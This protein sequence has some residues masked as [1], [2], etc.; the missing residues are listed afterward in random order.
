MQL[1]SLMKHIFNFIYLV[2]LIS[3]QPV[4]AEEGIRNK[5]PQGFPGNWN[6]QKS[7][8]AD[9]KPEITFHTMQRIAMPGTYGPN[10]KMQIKDC[11]GCFLSYNTH[12]LVDDKIITETYHTFNADLSDGKEYPETPQVKDGVL[13]FQVKSMSRPASAVCYDN[14]MLCKSSDNG[15]NCSPLS[16]KKSY[17]YEWHADKKVLTNLPVKFDSTVERGEEAKICKGPTIT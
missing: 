17:T 11:E 13:H 15:A 12:Y 1:N 14:F 3:F 9:F 10:F 16:N 8:E 2:V 7:L 4:A 6:Y 5:A